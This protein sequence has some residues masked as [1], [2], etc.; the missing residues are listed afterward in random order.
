MRFVIPSVLVLAAAV[1]LADE[2]GVRTWS[3]NSG[4]FTLDAMLVDIED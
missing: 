1:S 2:R 3:D 4:Q